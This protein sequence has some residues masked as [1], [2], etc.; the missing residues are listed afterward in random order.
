[1]KNNKEIV[2]RKQYY[3]SSNLNAGEER[4]KLKINSI[5][6]SKCRLSRQAFNLYRG[7]V[8]GED[9]LPYKLLNTFELIKAVSNTVFDMINAVYH[10]KTLILSG[11]R[12][13]RSL[14]P[15]I[16]Q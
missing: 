13:R 8:S 1:M 7:Y 16:R 9:R 14:Y 4:C 3:L 2:N 12:F 10:D 15:I 6:H 5:W 11:L